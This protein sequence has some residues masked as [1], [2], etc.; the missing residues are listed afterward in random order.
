MDSAP[1]KRALHIFSSPDTFKLRLEVSNW[2]PQIPQEI[3]L[4]DFLKNCIRVGSIAKQDF[5]EHSRNYFEEK[6][7][8]QKRRK[9]IQS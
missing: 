7:A 9:T 3:S 8:S 6:R 1:N 5:S 4:T 2:T